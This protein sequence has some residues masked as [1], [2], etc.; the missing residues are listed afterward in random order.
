MPD[1][2]HSYINNNH[3]LS[4]HE[5]VRI[6]LVGARVHDLELGRITWCIGTND[7]TDGI[8]YLFDT[9]T[10]TSA[11][12]FPYGWIVTLTLTINATTIGWLLKNWDW[13]RYRPPSSLDY[14]VK[15]QLY[16]GSEKYLKDLKQKEALEATDWSIV[17]QFL[18]QKEIYPE[19]PVRTKDVMADIRLR[20]LIGSAR[21]IGAY[22]Q[23]VSFHPGRKDV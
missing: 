22:T 10:N 14:S 20:I 2:Y 16:E 1:K 17:E 7:G 18:P 5:T 11:S 4:D 12:T 19:M 23:T 13:Q 6:W 3:I 21:S 15:E 8:V 9:R